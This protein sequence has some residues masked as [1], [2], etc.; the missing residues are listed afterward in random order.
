[1]L[2]WFWDIIFTLHWAEDKLGQFR[3]GCFWI[4]VNNNWS[5]STKWT[6]RKFYLAE[7]RKSH[8]VQHQ[9]AQR[10]I[11][12]TLQ[13]L[14]VQFQ[15]DKKK[16]EDNTQQTSV[17]LQDV[18][19]TSSTRLQHNNFSSSK[20]SWRRLART[21]WRHVLKTS[22]NMSWKHLQDVLDTK[23]MGIFVSHKSKCVCI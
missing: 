2:I 23:K 15:E 20:T 14:K 16:V 12:F 22:W 4:I 11:K 3:A 8:V 13:I 19:K 5:I 18:L 21:S 9:I 6:I 7:K 17:G 10:L 1:M